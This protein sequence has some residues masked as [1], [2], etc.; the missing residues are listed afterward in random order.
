MINLSTGSKENSKNHSLHET[1]LEPVTCG[2][3]DSYNQDNIVHQT[4]QDVHNNGIFDNLSTLHHEKL[5]LKLAAL[6]ER[7]LQT[8]AA[9]TEPTNANLLTLLK[10]W[11]NLPEAVK[12]SIASIAKATVTTTTP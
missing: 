5:A 6:A 8:N 11:D 10:T 2:S 9:K 1:G 4:P 12:T 3:E 7:S